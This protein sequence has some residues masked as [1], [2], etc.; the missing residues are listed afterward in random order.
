M[1]VAIFWTSLWRHEFEINLIFLMKS[2]FL[3]GQKSLDKNLN[4]LRTKIRNK[5]YFLSFLKGYH[6]SK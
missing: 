2:F 1:F 3:H 4:I 5:K 6:L